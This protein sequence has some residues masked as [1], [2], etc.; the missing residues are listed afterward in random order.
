MMENFRLTG[1]KQ[2]SSEKIRGATE[3]KHGGTAIKN[4][5]ERKFAESNKTGNG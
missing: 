4:V 3:G 2:C 5:F 1:T